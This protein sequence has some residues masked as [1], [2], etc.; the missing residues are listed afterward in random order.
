MPRA[1]ERYTSLGRKH[2][3]GVRCAVTRCAVYV[4]VSVL[5]WRKVP[6]PFSFSLEG[7]LLLVHQVESRSWP[8]CTA[9]MLRCST[10]ENRVS[11]GGTLRRRHA[12][13]HTGK[14]RLYRRY[15]APPVC[16]GAHWKITCVSATLSSQF[17][18]VRYKLPI[19][20]DAFFCTAMCQPG[21]KRTCGASVSVC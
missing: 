11:L 4:W 17:V 5:Q 10:P 7:G 6:L 12:A 2:V 9:G 3:L 19:L 1:L 14:P 18:C 16:C 20:Q 21:S 13:V 8:D 15:A